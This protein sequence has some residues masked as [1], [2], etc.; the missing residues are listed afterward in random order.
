MTNCKKQSGVIMTLM[1]LVCCEDL[2]QHPSHDYLQKTEWG[3]HDLDAAG[4]LW[5]IVTM[6]AQQ[7]L[8]KC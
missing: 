4:L 7:V 1:L 6:Q 5:G 2:W 8:Y 3:H